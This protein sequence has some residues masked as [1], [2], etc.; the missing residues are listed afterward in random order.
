MQK[1]GSDKPERTDN[2]L[3]EWQTALDLNDRDDS[4]MKSILPV[5]VSRD[6][7]SD[8]WTDGT[9]QELESLPKVVHKPTTMTMDRHLE[10][11]G[12]SAHAKEPLTTKDVVGTIMK[13]QSRISIRNSCLTTVKDAND[14]DATT[15]TSVEFRETDLRTATESICNCIRAELAR[16]VDQKAATKGAGGASSKPETR[17]RSSSMHDFGNGEK[18]R[19][20]IALK[21][22]KGGNRT[23]REELFET[24]TDLVQ[25][26]MGSF[27]GLLGYPPIEDALEAITDQLFSK[28]S[29]TE[30]VVER[31][32]FATHAGLV[33]ACARVMEGAETEV[34]LAAAKIIEKLS[35]QALQQTVPRLL[36]IQFGRLMKKHLLNAS[37]DEEDLALTIISRIAVLPLG[38]NSLLR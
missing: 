31:A 37:K 28:E 6:N 18:Q 27:D 22:L 36:S 35:R 16:G 12:F 32:Q 13:Y 21:S 5:F 20:R 25:G 19:M 17:P 8:F 14:G 23:E 9:A 1:L 34:R 7:E 29:I 24:I 38:V 15:S 2:V 10:K 4:G 11:L 3:L 30:H 33:E 26:L